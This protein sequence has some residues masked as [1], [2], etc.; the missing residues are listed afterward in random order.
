[1]CKQKKDV[2][3]ISGQ[4]EDSLFL[5]KI[6]TVKKTCEPWMYEVQV[7]DA[8]QPIVWEADSGADICVLPEAQFSKELGNLTPVKTNISGPDRKNLKCLGKFEAVC[9]FEEK[10]VITDIYVMKDIKKPLLGRPVLE[11]LGILKRV[12]KVE[13]T[14]PWVHKFP[15][16]FKEQLGTMKTTPYRISLVENAEPYNLP[17]SRRV[18]LPLMPKV[19]KEIERMQSLGIISP[20]THPTD[21]CAGMVVVPKSTG[22]VRITTD[23]TFLNN[24][25]RREKFQLPA[26]QSVL[27]GLAGSTHYT[28]LDA[29]SGYWQIP[30]HEDSRDLTCFITPFGRFH[31]N[32]LPMRISSASEVYSRKMKV[33]L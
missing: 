7:G 22:A 8:R 14:N 19:K 15:E 33:M 21:W 3:K 13:S 28:K 17:V 20:V 29:A 4:E 31:Y 11:E 6:H 24:F 5:G 16:L 12:K 25:V 30:L 10:S 18:A 9:R 26:V 32:K 1:M 23:F 27:A 2:K